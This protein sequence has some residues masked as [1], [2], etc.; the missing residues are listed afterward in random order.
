MLATTF[1]S[2]LQERAETTTA[3]VEEGRKSSSLIQQEDQD[4][5]LV[6]VLQPIS[7]NDIPR[8]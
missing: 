2:L 4:M 3:D 5:R 6:G 8:D 1:A 7:A